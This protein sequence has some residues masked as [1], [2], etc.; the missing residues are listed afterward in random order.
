[1]IK[2]YKC[3]EQATG[4]EGRYIRWTANIQRQGVCQNPACLLRKAEKNRAKK[5]ASNR[6]KNKK[7]L[8]AWKRDNR[9]IKGW[10]LDA[11][12]DG[13][14]PW[15]RKRDKDLGCIVCGRKDKSLYHAGHFMSVGSRPELQFH[16]YNCHKQCMGCN[17]S[18][19]SVA[20]RYRKNL[21]DRIGLEMVE[22]LETY[23]A[24]V[25]WTVEE[26]KEIKAHYLELIKTLAQRD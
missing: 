14:Q 22:Y 7:E 4:C 16:P 8:L 5:E 23:H 9:T 10:C 2:K 20:G 6:Q 24:T 12:R 21:V 26:I 25:K 18:V 17:T 19:S 3:R 11:R 15:V 1:M 13:F